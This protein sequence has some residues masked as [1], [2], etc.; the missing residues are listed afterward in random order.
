MGNDHACQ[1]VGIGTVRIKMYDGL[2]RT[3]TDVRHVPDLKKN[4]ISL[5]T[6][7]SNGCRFAAE[8]GVLKVVRASLVLMKGNKHGNLYILMGKTVTG[9]VAVGTSS[10]DCTRIWH[11]RLGHMTEK[12]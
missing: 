4:L 3:L 7:D 2:V 6:L 11:M 1:M 8:G 9:S 5:G 12:G 10:S